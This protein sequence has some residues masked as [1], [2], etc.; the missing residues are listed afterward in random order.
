M[1]MLLLLK[2]TTGFGRFWSTAPVLSF[3]CQTPASTTTVVAVEQKD[4]GTLD[5]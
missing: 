4:T 2:N 1:Y 5:T 3:G